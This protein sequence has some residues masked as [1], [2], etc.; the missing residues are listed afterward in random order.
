MGQP[1]D[2]YYKWL[3]I[4]AEEQP[5]NHYR[6]LGVKLFEQD[7]DVIQAAA[8]QRMAHLR[9]YQTGQYADWSQRLLNEVS[10]AKICLLNP[11]KKDDYDQQLREMGESASVIAI[12]EA[13]IF[14]DDSPSH[15]Q[16][17]SNLGK[18]IPVGVFVVVLTTMLAVLIGGALYWKNSVS[19]P[20]AEQRDE[21]AVS[22]GKD[23]GESKPGTPATTAK[24]PDKHKDTLVKRTAPASDGSKKK[25][26]SV[27]SNT[28][29][30]ADKK[31]A[32]AKLSLKPN[33][34]NSEPTEEST[35]KEEPQQKEP[36]K[37][38][39]SKEE[40]AKEDSSKE[41]ES[42]DKAW[43]N[44][45]PDRAAI[46][47]DAAQEA[48]MKLAHDLYKDEFAKA[49]TAE[50]K[51]ALAKKL[52][53]LAIGS[54]DPDAGTY[55]L[56]RLARDISVQASSGETAFEAIDALAERYQVDA[57]EMKFDALT[58]F[59]KKAR[60]SPQHVSL[61]EQASRLNEDAAEAGNYTQAINLTKLVIVEAGAGRNKELLQTAKASL[62]ELQKKA[63]FAAEFEAAKDVLK[64]KPDDGTANVTVGI[65]FAFIQN[66]WTKAL[67][68]LAKGD[69]ETLQKLA[70]QENGASRANLDQQIVVADA[71]WEAAQ[72]AE[73]VR[74]TVMLRRANYWYA[75][76]AAAGDI[77][78]L[79]KI[80]VEKRLDDLAK[81]EHDASPAGP[82]PRS[83]IIFNKWFPL[84]TSPNDLM[85][86]ET[87]DCRYTYVNRII[88]L[89]QWGM[90]CAIS[91]KD[92][93][94]RAKVK[95]PRS[96]RIRLYLRNSEQG[97]YYLQLASDSWSIVKLTPRPGG[98]QRRNTGQ[99]HLWG[100]TDTLNSIPVSR[101]Y[102]DLVFEM[103]FSAVGDTLTAYFNRQSVVQAKDGSFNEG[104]VGIGTDT[105]N[106]LLVT[107]IEMLIPSKVSL[108]EDR[109][110]AVG[111]PKQAREGNAKKPNSKR[112]PAR[113]ANGDL[114]NFDTKAPLDNRARLKK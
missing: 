22:Q 36:A 102:N 48:A 67:S 66:K 80:K 35:A 5:P 99:A 11:E 2:P 94:I 45:L 98:G 19:E 24:A 6:L 17:I 58:A 52:L 38:K 69:D 79:T 43:G 44:H 32:S 7:P 75:K 56:L 71:W 25:V 76:V 63:K 104:T 47:S 95:R 1:F 42:Q 27:A 92:A 65:Y 18:R 54:K 72:T 46:P 33:P 50:D 14:D 111:S 51:L 108:V 15:I 101:N 105:S 90:F 4:P 78:G 49:K 41:D 112:S 20:L 83:T 61:A 70:K 55:V 60:T 93:M 31:P 88:D 13:I 64:D 9:T 23:A 96:A 110:A 87:E 81:I 34:A 97:C 74:R 103:G 12:E 106:G 86:W 73:G 62:Q 29:S 3:A 91:A 37:E 10:A 107:D 68:H 30:T 53:S 82:K 39:P 77:S 100:N 57:L 85:G 113:D 8:D 114:P 109:R 21:S 26:I 89:Q 59:A 40:T 84:L 16:S 28:K